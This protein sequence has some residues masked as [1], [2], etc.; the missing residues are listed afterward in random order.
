MEY[1]TGGIGDYR[2]S[3]MNIRNEDG[4]MGSEFFYE[5]YKIREGKEKLEGLPASFGTVDEVTTL[6]ITCVDPGQENVIF[7]N[8]K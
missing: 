8:E 6:E 4:N 3:C 7:K 5:S 2:E 1:S